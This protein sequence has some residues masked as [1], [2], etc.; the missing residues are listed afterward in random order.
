VP[1][2]TLTPTPPAN[3]F[4]PT[5]EVG[6]EQ[7]LYPLEVYFCEECSHAQLL[8]VVPPVELFRDY[9]YVSGTSKV[10]R[11]H[12]S[13]YASEVMQRFPLMAQELVVDIGSNDGTLLRCFQESGFRVL[14]VDPA[15]EIAQQAT[16]GGIETINGFFTPALAREIRD[17]HGTAALV[18][19]NNVFAHIDDLAAV[20]E[21]VRVLLSPGGVFVFEVSYLLDVLEKTLFDTI[22]HEHLSYHTVEPLVRF[23][24]ANGMELIGADRVGSHGGSLRVFAQL[25]GGPHSVAE[26]VDERLAEEELLGLNR[27]EALLQFGSRIAVVRDTVMSLLDGLRS[28]GT[29]LAGYGAP[30]KATTLLYHFGIG[31][32]TLEYIVDDSPLKQGLHTPGLHIP[33]FSAAALEEQ[34][35]DCLFILA[36][37]FAN[38][39]IKNQAAFRDSGGKFLVPL[40]EPTIQ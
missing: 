30:A 1:V 18:T 15:H 29:K 9:V 27:A 40:P 39:I 21:G 24:E 32:E 28:R 26:S 34:P 23:F 33:V 7:A 5:A 8:D 38:S 25:K 36:W 22:Y 2:L 35:V 17:Q 16:E 3:A 12:F 14:G 10:F 20:A 31:P 37:N 4:V 11:D 13:H 19:A 6:L